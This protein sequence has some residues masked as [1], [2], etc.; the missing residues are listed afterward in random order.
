LGA[1]AIRRIRTLPSACPAFIPAKHRRSEEG[2]SR[3][4]HRTCRYKQ[5]VGQLHA[6][7]SGARK[8]KARDLP[9]NHFD[10]RCGDKRLY[11]QSISSSI[12]LDAWTANCASL[13]PVQHPTVNRGPVC[14][15][16]H[17]PTHRIDFANKMAL[18][19]T[20]NRRI[21]GH[22][23]QI[24]TAKGYKGGSSAAARGSAGSFAARMASTNDQNVEHPAALTLA[25]G[26]AQL[27]R[28]T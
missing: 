6:I 18:A 19:Y 2:S 8:P 26:L 4:D 21:A 17:N 23:S 7:Y 11:R 22:L 28:F 1:K 14:R 24:I 5:A 25:D 16:G 10:A 12:S 27:R 15:D 13:A 3:N 9:L 20:A